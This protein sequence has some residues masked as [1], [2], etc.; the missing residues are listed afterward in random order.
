MA[1]WAT[2]EL[3]WA[4]RRDSAATQ[5]M[6]QVGNERR[7]GL[8]SSLPILGHAASQDYVDAGRQLRPERDRRWRRVVEMCHGDRDVRVAHEWHPPGEAL[9][10]DTG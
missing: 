7:T 6:A 5:C 4:V 10:G 9:E 1:S 2:G 3:G 8:V